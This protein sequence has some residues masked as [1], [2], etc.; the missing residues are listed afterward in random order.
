MRGSTGTE[1]TGTL[2]EANK[3][4]QSINQLTVYH[5]NN[6]IDYYHLN[7]ACRKNYHWV[8]LAGLTII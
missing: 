8:F 2:E 6:I 5:F 3:S 4:N 7:L 1:R